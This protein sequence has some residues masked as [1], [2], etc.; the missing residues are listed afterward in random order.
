MFPANY[1]YH[2][3]ASFAEACQAMAAYGEDAK[4]LAGGQTLIPMMKLRLLTPAD[5][6][7]LGRVPEARYV[8][9]RENILEIGALTT[10]A[11]VGLSEAARA[12][13]ILADCGLGIADAQVRNMGTVGGSLAE[14]DPCSCWPAALLAL[15]ARVRSLGPGGERMQTVA[16]LLRDAYTPNLEAAE[17]ITAIEIDREMLDGVGAFVAFK[18]TAP[19]YP[20][21]SCAL[22]M[23]FDGDRVAHIGLSLGCVALTSLRVPGVEEALKGRVLS[24]G[25]IGEVAAWAAETAEPVAD[26]KGS[27]AYKRSLVQGLVHR[28]FAVALGR[29]ANTPLMETHTYYG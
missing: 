5:L 1:R 21:A 17:L 25:L 9:W 29:K 13:P 15:D 6:I 2:R 26:N 22:R 16:E 14:A 10:H 8:R 19:A 28:A 18:R 23:A 24:D 3:V 12:Y 7:D 27:E 20:T 4:L 11:A